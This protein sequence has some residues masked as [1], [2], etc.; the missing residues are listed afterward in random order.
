MTGGTDVPA[1]LTGIS[2]LVAAIGALVVSVL[3]AWR[4]SSARRAADAAKVIAEDS[5]IEI[6]ATKQGV[7]ELGKQ[8]DGRLK[9]LLE[10]TASASR[11]AGRVE[12]RQEERTDAVQGRPS[13]IEKAPALPLPDPTPP[14]PGPHPGH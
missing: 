8:L 13:T 2:T 6:I 11:A 4:A 14:T 5:K 9:L 1:T 12:G 3:G 7:F 10:T